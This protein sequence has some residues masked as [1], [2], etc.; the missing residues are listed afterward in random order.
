[1]PTQPLVTVL[2]PVFN[3]GEYLKLSIESILAQTYKDFEF[4]I[5]NDCST[6]NSMETIRSFNDQRIAVHTNAANM[7]QT[8]SLNVGLKLAKGKYIVINDADD[9]SLPQRIEKQLNFIMKHPEYP[10]VGT[11]AYIMDKR[12]RVIRVFSKPIDPKEIC[13]WILTDTPLIHG[14][15]IMNKEII[16]AERGYDEYY[17]TSQDY[18]FWSRLMRKG[19]RVIN[20]PD[21]LVVIRHYAESMSFKA[22]D[23]Q[24]IEN[25]KILLA[26]INGLTARKITEG[27]AVRHRKFFIA[28]DQLTDD[29]FKKAE[30]LFVAAYKNLNSNFRQENSFIEADLRGKLFK[31]YTKLA[32]SK[33]REGQPNEARKVARH[34]LDVYGTNHLLLLIWLLSFTGRWSLDAALFFHEKSKAL[35][36]TMSK[37]YAAARDK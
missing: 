36:A 3:G 17:I 16:L 23:R 9:L 8:K 15:V 4:L 30:E 20:M 18:E 12:G 21:I 5:I 29:E 14:A 33:F 37:F 1:M 31:P 11:S 7:G 6:D 25:G 34:Y 32:L 10:V 2:M 19:Y 28:P 27:E 24:T 22:S 35:S 26:N 13:L